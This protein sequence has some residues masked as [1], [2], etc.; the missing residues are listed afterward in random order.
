MPLTVSVSKMADK[1]SNDNVVL[2]FETLSVE[3]AV[4]LV[5]ADH[6]GAISLFIGEYVQYMLCVCRCV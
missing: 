6:A 4:S 1:D 2:T 3:S 5:K